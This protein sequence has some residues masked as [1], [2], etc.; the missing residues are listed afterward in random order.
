MV[1]RYLYHNTT[2]AAHT[3]RRV[4]WFPY[5]KTTSAAGNSTSIQWYLY[6]LHQTTAAAGTSKRVYWYLYHQTKQLQEPVMSLPQD[7]SRYPNSRYLLVVSLPQDNSSSRN[8][9]RAGRVGGKRAR[10]SQWDYSFKG[11]IGPFP[12]CDSGSRPSSPFS[13]ITSQYFFLCYLIR[14]LSLDKSVR[15]L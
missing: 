5:N 12:P 4:Q 2:A 1:Q 14:I 9:M 7:N 6:L 8:Q 3:S 13:C 15:K 11:R 10:A